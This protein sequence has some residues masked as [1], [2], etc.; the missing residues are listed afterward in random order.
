M[1]TDAIEMK[2]ETLFHNNFIISID[3]VKISNSKELDDIKD[4]MPLNL[5]LVWDAETNFAE[6]NED[7]SRF[8]SIEWNG[9]RRV[10]AKKEKQSLQ[11]RLYIIMRNKTK[12]IEVVVWTDKCQKRKTEKVSYSSVDNVTFVTN[13]SIYENAV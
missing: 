10:R 9:T 3:F 12:R 1:C 2:Q 4:S 13:Y 7:L 8:E 11:L 6:E 5:L